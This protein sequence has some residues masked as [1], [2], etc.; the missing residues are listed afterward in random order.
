M[1]NTTI[2]YSTA[3]KRQVVEEL[4]TGK[5][6][7]VREARRAYGITGAETVSLWIRKYGDPSMQRKVIVMCPDEQSELEKM[8]KRVRELEQALAQ[9]KL[10]ELVERS[11]YHVV[12]EENGIKDP[13]AYKK[14]LEPKLRKQDD[15]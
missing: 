12:C 8:R 5:W 7:T 15:A 11:F 1:S 6:S 4:R 2:R 10:D 9:A 13:E 3:F 14:N